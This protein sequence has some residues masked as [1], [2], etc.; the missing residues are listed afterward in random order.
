M[1]SSAPASGAGSVSARAE[2]RASRASMACMPQL[3][4]PHAMRSP[5]EACERNKDPI[6]AV[7][8]EEL[9]GSTRLLEVGSG[10][11]QHAVHFAAALPQLLWQPSELAENLPPLAERI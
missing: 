2:R 11:G 9:A 8:R 7:L 10:T 1:S 4:Q 5:S 6:P 3:S